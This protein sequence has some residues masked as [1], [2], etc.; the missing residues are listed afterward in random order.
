ME[1]VSPSMVTIPETRSLNPSGG[2]N[3]PFLHTCTSA[4]G[5]NEIHDS[6]DRSDR[7]DEASSA[8]WQNQVWD[9]VCFQRGLLFTIFCLLLVLAAII[10]EGLVNFDK[11]RY[12]FYTHEA[13][14]ART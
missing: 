9:W 13:S 10:Y 5:R 7:G 8:P 4:T 11:Y 3:T 1:E 6:M 2:L 12:E 14:Q